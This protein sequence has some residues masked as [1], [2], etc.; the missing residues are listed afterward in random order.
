MEM[1]NSNFGTAADLKA[2][3][4]AL[5]ARGMWLMVDIVAN[6]ASSDADVSQNVPFSSAADYHDCN[7]CPSGCNV[8]D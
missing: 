5:H 4:D 6:H 8:N 1:I 2:L 3:S 7:G